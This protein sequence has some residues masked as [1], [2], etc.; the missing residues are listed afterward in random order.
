MFLVWSTPSVLGLL[1][2]PGEE[3]MSYSKVRASPLGKSDR[4]KR[5]FLG[6]VTQVDLA[7][8]YGDTSQY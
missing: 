1:D 8:V 5:I 7:E 3:T 4:P 2:V 6:Y